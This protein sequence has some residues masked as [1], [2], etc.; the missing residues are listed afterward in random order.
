MALTLGGIIGA[1]GPFFRIFELGLD[2]SRSSKRSGRG[3]GAD[4]VS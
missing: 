4:A 3:Y 1:C 2:V